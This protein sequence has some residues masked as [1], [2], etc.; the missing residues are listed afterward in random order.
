[1]PHSPTNRTLRT[2]LREAK[3][4]NPTCLVSHFIERRAPTIPA[5]LSKVQEEKN[6]CPMAYTIYQRIRTGVTVSERA[7]QRILLCRSGISSISDSCENMLFTL[8][9]LRLIQT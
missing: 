6:Q 8:G 1:M 9:P 5:V 7:V 2:N 3:D 4:P